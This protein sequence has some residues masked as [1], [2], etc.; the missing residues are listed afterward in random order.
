MRD[1]VA[2]QLLDLNLGF[3]QSLAAPFVETRNRPQP[4]VLR[5]LEGV[6][7]RAS[8]LDLGC[9]SGLVARELARRGHIGPYVGIDS[10]TEM[11]RSAEAACSHP[12]ARFCLQDLTRP[13]WRR[14]AGGPF[15]HIL[16]FAVLHHIPGV[17][18]RR[19]VLRE[20]RGAAAERGRLILSTWNFL[21]SER[22]RARRVPWEEIGLT[23]S[24]VDPGDYLVDWR[25]GGYGVRYAHAFAEGEL[26][27]LADQAGFR[28]IDRYESDGEGGRLGHYEIWAPGKV[29][30]D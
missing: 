30:Q 28:V 8:V 5:A 23:S 17:E 22:L 21:S 24:D 11:V 20:A 6:D 14:A 2:I 26:E 13:A 19:A 9:G 3:Y 29:T 7:P 27:R 10:S 18:R 4:G 1:E 15:D 16:A 12:Q 25:H